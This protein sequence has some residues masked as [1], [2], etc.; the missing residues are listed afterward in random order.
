MRMFLCLNLIRLSGLF[1]PNIGE[2]RGSGHSD[3]ERYHV[4]PSIFDGGLVH[5]KHLINPLGLFFK[6]IRISKVERAL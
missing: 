4:K 6:Q 5:T 3:L 1:L 2:N